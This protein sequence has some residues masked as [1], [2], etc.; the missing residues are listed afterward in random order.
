MV[1]EYGCVYS[2]SSGNSVTCYEELF[3]RECPVLG[4]GG[5]VCMMFMRL[6]MWAFNTI[7][8]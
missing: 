7:P 5:V 6:Y 3:P 2:E 8:P 1:Y 4:F